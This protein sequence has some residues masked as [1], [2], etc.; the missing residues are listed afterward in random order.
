MRVPVYRRDVAPAPISGATL[1]PVATPDAFGA[2]AGR[3]LE[4][5]GQ[6]VMS[7]ADAAN[8]VRQLDDQARAKE[9]DDAYSD[10][11][12]ERMYGEG[13]FL[14]L[15]GRNAVDAREAFEKEAGAQ[16]MAFGKGLTPGAARAY[17][18]A[19]Q[20][21]MNGVQQQAAVHTARARKSWYRE[22]SDARIETFG[23][24]ALA[25]FD[26]PR[27]RQKNIAA[28]IAEL[29]EQAA[30]TGMGG[31]ALKL[32][33]SEFVSGVHRG[34]ALRM[35]QS[36]PL[37]AEGYV[38]EVG[39][40]LTPKDRFDLERALKRPIIEA[41][42]LRNVSD[43]L[44]GVAAGDRRPPVQEESAA[45]AGDRRPDP[46]TGNRPA[47][48]NL[49]PADIASRM[50][51]LREDTDTDAISDF[52]KRSA[53][54][55]IDPQTAEWGAAFVNAVL[56][57]A[58]IEGTGKLN[59]RSFLSFGL[60]V[61][62]PA[63]G[64][65]VV[66]RRGDD[67]A[68][69]HV[70]LFQGYDANGNIL[71][72]GGNQGDAVSVA[73]FSAD[74]VLGFR[75]AGPVNEQV[76]ALPNY[77][78]QGLATIHDRLMKIKDPVE[79]EATRKKLDA[80]MISAKRQLDARREEAQ[81]WAES[82]VIADPSFDPHKMPAQV[83]AVIGVS[84]MTALLN[85]QEKVRAQDEPETDDRVLFDLQTQYANDPEAFARTDLFQHRD[86]FSDDDWKRVTGWREKALTD[87]RA[88]REESLDLSSAFSQSQA[89]LDAAGITTTGL[90][91]EAR[92]KAAGR[93]ARFQNV[94]TSEIDRFRRENDKHP[95]PEEVRKIINRLLLPVVMR[96]P[97]KRAMILPGLFGSGRSEG[98]LFEAPFRSDTA[99][100]EVEVSYGDIPFDMRRRIELDLG[101]ELGRKPSE[102]EVTAHYEA[103]RLAQ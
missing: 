8:R 81:A 50:R 9:A 91:G 68:A 62:K 101:Q 64:D 70:G 90:K 33:E 27:V 10:W 79:R 96:D 19:S 28:G 66:L 37:A 99:T 71:V 12:R 65:V 88:A 41:K 17:E 32:R 4:R 24:D 3:G 36:D 83:Q 89:A 75:T 7:V 29:R 31:D 5:L 95:E 23:N 74:D 102:E 18:R 82:Q 92:K 58:G 42:A 47:A 44:G 40:G 87:K 43:I 69:G 72:L 93:I 73:P 76:T 84:S 55:E 48:G 26:Q 78:P 63:P 97:G 25:N 57:A 85:Y 103:F 52:I 30:M 60:P 86:K 38:K 34:V 20:A 94:L 16:R 46:V 49:T 2:G 98:R 1:D 35:A 15:E 51:G 45:V 13:G 39:D 53:G 22:A 11:L 61:D 77:G 59:P 100:T 6:G 67:P 21:R 80:M 14:T 56:G 54:I